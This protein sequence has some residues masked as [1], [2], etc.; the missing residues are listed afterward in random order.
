MHRAIG[1]MVQHVQT[2][3]AAYEYT[4]ARNLTFTMTST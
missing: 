1:G 2:D 3:G 4:H